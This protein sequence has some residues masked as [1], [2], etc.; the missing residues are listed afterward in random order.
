MRILISFF[1]LALLTACGTVQ[2]PVPQTLVV[3]KTIYVSWAMPAYL[4][5]CAGN[6]PPLAVPHIAASDPHAGS[7]V[8]KNVIALRAHDAAEAAAHDDCANTLAAAVAAAAE[9]P[10]EEEKPQ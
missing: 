2:Q 9:P 6:P 1:V 7:A 5:T 10:P 3:T 8:A 4:K